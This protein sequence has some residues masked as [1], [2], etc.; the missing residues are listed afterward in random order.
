M[1]EQFRRGTRYHL[2]QPNALKHGVFTLVAMLPGEDPKLFA[3]LHAGLI[4]EWSPDGPT[5]KDAVLS[6]AKALWRK[7]RVQKFLEGKIMAC[8]L[9]G[10]HPAFDRI[11]ALKGVSGVLEVAPYCLDELISR[12]SED[13]QERLKKKFPPLDFDSNAERA[14]AIKKEIDLVILPELELFDK[15]LEVSFLEASDILTP[16]DFKHEIALEERIDATIDR[17]I[18]RLIQIKAMKQILGQQ[19]SVDHKSSRLDSAAAR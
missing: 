7:A 18:K 8:R 11:H 17:L 1:N 10:S 5:E 13:L 6:L 4:Q 2:K 15:P 9:D 14:Q 12:L 16:D 19:T 3:T